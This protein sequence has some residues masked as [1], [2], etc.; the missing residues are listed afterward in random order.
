MNIRLLDEI[1]RLSEAMLPDDRE[2]IPETAF[3]Y[4]VCAISDATRGYQSFTDPESVE[5]ILDGL[6]SD[7]AEARWRH[8]GADGLSA[9]LLITQ[10]V[11]A[12]RSSQLIRQVMQTIIEDQVDLDVNARP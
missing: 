3:E 9:F 10:F 5:L 8:D 4:A 1:E 6:V 2:S 11:S 12:Y 7:K